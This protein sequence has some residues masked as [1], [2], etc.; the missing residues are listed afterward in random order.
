[1]I[2]TELA[3]GVAEWFQQLG[4]CW[5]VGSQPDIRTRHPDLSQARADR[6]LAGDKRSAPSGA[7]LLPV[8]IGKGRSFIADAINIGSSVP[9][10]TAVVVADVPPTNVVTLDLPH[11]G[12]EALGHSAA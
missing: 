6:V 7:A 8:I 9:H 2:F 4:N 11:F 12:G 5:I 1:M 10:L 3:C